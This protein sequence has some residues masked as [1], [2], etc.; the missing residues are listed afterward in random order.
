MKHIRDGLAMSHMMLATEP[1]EFI[2]RA[3]KK[4][5]VNIGYGVVFLL[6]AVL[7]VRLRNPWL[8]PLS[9]A[10]YF[11]LTFIRYA[12]VRRVTDG[13]RLLYMMLLSSVRPAIFVGIVCYAMRTLWLL[14]RGV[15]IPRQRRKLA[16][17]KSL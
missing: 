9:V 12:V 15:K 10:L 13:R 3:Q 11:V 16:D 1:S 5:Y 4:W 7:S 17:L 6:I 8:L 14:I 2:G